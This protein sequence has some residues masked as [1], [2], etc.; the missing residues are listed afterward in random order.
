M[1][2]SVVRKYEVERRFL[3]QA[4]AGLLTKYGEGRR[5]KQ[6]YLLS[7]KQSLRIRIGEE[8]GAVLTAKSGTGIRRLETE[9][10]V[11]NNIAEALFLKADQG[12]IEKLR[13]YIG[14]WELDQFLGRL[15]GL[16]LLEIEL[17]SD[18]DKLPGAFPDGVTVIREVTNDNRFTSSSLAGLSASNRSN[19]VQSAYRE[20]GTS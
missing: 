13:W 3:V 6:A 15:S 11:P 2:S 7:G 12:V 10:V 18:G 9:V 1:C 20:A 17:E 5:L 8:R 14:P 16:F 19:F 4:E